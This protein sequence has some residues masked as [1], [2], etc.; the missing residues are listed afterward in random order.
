MEKRKCLVRRHHKC[1]D[2]AED[3]GKPCCGFGSKVCPYCGHVRRETCKPDVYPNLA[4]GCCSCRKR[5]LAR[6]RWRVD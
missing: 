4:D 5:I 2:C 3:H 6:F 1:G